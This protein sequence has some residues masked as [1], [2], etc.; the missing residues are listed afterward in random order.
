MVGGRAVS[1]HI[2]LRGR[3][4]IVCNISA[5]ESVCKGVSVGVVKTDSLLCHV[6]LRFLVY[7]HDSV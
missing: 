2:Y 5:C 6:F 4:S 7:V 3:V 1:F